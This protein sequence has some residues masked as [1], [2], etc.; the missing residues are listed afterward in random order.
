MIDIEHY[1]TYYSLDKLLEQIISKNLDTNHLQT[2]S[3]KELFDI[4]IDNGLDDLAEYLYIYQGIEFCLSKLFNNISF[5][6]SQ[7]MT[8]NSMVT[9]ENTGNNDFINIDYMS[10]KELDRKRIIQRLMALKKYSKIRN[11]NKEF[12]Y[13]FLTKYIHL[14]Q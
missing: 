4:A 8:D 7:T 2:L 6:I 9:I 14:I 5:S 1:S 11:E 3:H 12:Y 10:G 13:K